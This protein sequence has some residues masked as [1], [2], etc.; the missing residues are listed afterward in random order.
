MMGIVQAHG[1]WSII[2]SPTHPLACIIHCADM[3]SS[4]IMGGININEY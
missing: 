3:L 4:Q 1:G 2:N